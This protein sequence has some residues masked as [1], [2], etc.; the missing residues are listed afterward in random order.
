L[1]TWALAL[2]G[3]MNLNLRAAGGAVDAVTRLRYPAGLADAE[4]TTMV[5][6][7]FVAAS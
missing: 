3:L 4:N 6:T 1:R 7:R 2:E 5:H